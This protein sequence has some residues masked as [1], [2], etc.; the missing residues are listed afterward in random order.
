MARAI[1]ETAKAEKANHILEKAYELYEKGTFKSIKMIDI[2]KCEW[3]I[4]RYNVQ[5]FFYKRETI[6]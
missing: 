3:R 6:S 4:K 2:A 5:L 1:T